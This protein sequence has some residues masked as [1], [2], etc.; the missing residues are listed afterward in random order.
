[1]RAPS[2]YSVHASCKCFDD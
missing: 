1:M 2:Y